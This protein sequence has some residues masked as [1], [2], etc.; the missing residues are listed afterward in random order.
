MPLPGPT[1]FAELVDYVVRVRHSFVVTG[2]PNALFFSNQVFA[3]PATG[4]CKE[5]PTVSNLL[6]SRLRLGADEAATWGDPYF[7]IPDCPNPDDA[8]PTDPNPCRIA[9]PR[10]GNADSLFHYFSY[11]ATPVEAVRFSNPYLS[12]VLDLTSLLDLARPPEL[13]PEGAWPAEFARFKRSRIPRNYSER[14]VTLDGYIPW[15]EP[16]AVGTVPMVYPVRVIS[17]PE[18]GVAFIVD[19]GGR[20]GVA[21]VRGQIIRINAA[22]VTSGPL[23][24]ENFRVR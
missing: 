17:A 20:G 13:L 6:T 4:E 24:D 15:D 18:L 22:E 23:A 19:A 5:D 14:F 21:G 1:C 10:E 16:V 7:P 12:L 9:V 11:N 2:D 8:A 3:D